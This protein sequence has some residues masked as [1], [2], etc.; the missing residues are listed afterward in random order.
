[1]TG[2]NFYEQKRIKNY[3]NLNGI[4][5]R[6]RSWFCLNKIL[7]MKRNM[8]NVF[9]NIFM[10]MNIIFCERETSRLQALCAYTLTIS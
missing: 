1:M 4:K 10:S 7:I 2:Y 3:A 5:Q 6:T 8:T 9:F